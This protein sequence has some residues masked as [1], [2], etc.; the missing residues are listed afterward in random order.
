MPFEIDGVEY[1]PAKEV[2]AKAGV[3]RQTL[4]RW[5]QDGLIPQGNRYRGRHVVFS[6]EEVRVI[7]N[8]AN[9]IEPIGSWGPLFE[10]P[11]EEG[12]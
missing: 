7:E 6:P 5:R 12:G 8:H 2:A 9:R 3:S 4:W 11:S 1:L 10:S